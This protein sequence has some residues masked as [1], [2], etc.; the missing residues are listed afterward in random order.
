[1][2]SCSNECVNFHLTQGPWCDQVGHVQMYL[3]VKKQ[4]LGLYQLGQ[5][6]FLYF[7]VI[8][9]VAACFFSPPPHPLPPSYVGI[10]GLFSS[11]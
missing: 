3:M 4:S 7:Q 9:L 8:T 2:A 10:V 6:V 1:M 5:E 11:N